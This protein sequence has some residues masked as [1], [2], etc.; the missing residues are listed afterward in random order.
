MPVYFPD[1][2]E[3]NNTDNP[4]AN[5][6]SIK[7]GQF[8]VN[9]L[10]ELYSLSFEKLTE[11]ITRAWVTSESKYYV[12]T[13]I[14]NYSNVD[15]WTEDTGGSGGGISSG[16]INGN[17]LDIT[18]TDT[19]VVN[20][21]VTE[22]RNEITGVTTS[23]SSTLSLD[24]NNSLSSLTATLPNITGATTSGSSTLLLNRTNSLSDISVSLPTIT[25]LTLSAGVLSATRTNSLSALTVNIPLTTGVT[26]S[27]GVLS[28]ERA[29]TTSLTANIPVVTGVTFSSGTL[30][31][32]RATTTSLTA[33][34]TG[35]LSGLT[36]GRIPYAS[37]ATALTDVATLVWNNANTSLL[38]GN[39][40]IGATPASIEIQPVAGRAA[41]RL[42]ASTPSSPSTGELFYQTTNTEFVFQGAVRP[43]DASVSTM[44]SVNLRSTGIGNYPAFTGLV[45]TFVVATGS[46]FSGIL[47]GGNM[48]MLRVYG[49]LA[50]GTLIGTLKSVEST[51][52][53]SVFSENRGASGVH[54]LHISELFIRSSTGAMTVNVP[55]VIHSMQARLSRSFG[56]NANILGD[57]LYIANDDTISTSS[58]NHTINSIAKHG[59]MRTRSANG[60][61]TSSV[62]SWGVVHAENN[63][64]QGIVVN[65]GNAYGLSIGAIAAHSGMTTGNLY[66]V[67][68]KDY[69]GTTV[70]PAHGVVSSAPISGYSN[71]FQ[72]YLEGINANTNVGNYIGNKLGVGF[73]SLPT[74]A[75]NITALVDV[76]PATTA[77]AS[78]RIRSG[79]TPSSPND[80]DIW[81]DNTNLYIRINGVTRTVNVT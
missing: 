57:Y 69:S 7:G 37:S 59:S 65:N 1:I 56:T 42:Y 6:T 24:R 5:I 15:G 74:A 55:V 3:H 45:S 72:I 43:Q 33:N 80:G 75:S 51:S 62:V 73:A 30:T 40:S 16:V 2:L 46:S 35:L 21:D 13:D 12:L 58:N 49:S 26:F 17:S 39:P 29:T 18:N 14:T 27:A 52:N 25:G 22:L 64:G 76:G 70:T 71:R 60:V 31:L 41:L 61:F 53:G 4:I 23:G 11:R 44:T 63:T 20:I 77:T 9:D 68:I 50:G 28:L 34:I 47:D 66:G 36:A 54:S 32:E 79:A 19:S 78:L 8:V 48:F 81:F 38:I 10:S 67:H